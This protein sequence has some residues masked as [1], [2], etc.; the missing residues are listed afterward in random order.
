MAFGDGYTYALSINP[1]YA[2]PLSAHAATIAY[3]PSSR[4]SLFAAVV[5]ILL[6]VAPNGCPIACEFKKKNKK[7][8]KQNKTSVRVVG[9]NTSCVSTPV[10]DKEYVYTKKKTS[11]SVT[12]TTQRNIK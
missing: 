5:V 12:T 2:N 1:P 8:N 9:L 11:R 7:T 6:P 4:C 10:V 3:L